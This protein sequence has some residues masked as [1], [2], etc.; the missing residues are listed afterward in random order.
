M[1]I[2]KSITQKNIL[3]YQKSIRMAYKNLKNDRRKKLLKTYQK[4]KYC[5]KESL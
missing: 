5:L 1:L 4:K 2:K 3:S